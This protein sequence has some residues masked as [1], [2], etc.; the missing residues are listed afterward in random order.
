LRDTVNLKEEFGGIFTKGE[1]FVFVVKEGFVFEPESIAFQLTEHG[2][3]MEFTA[4]P[5]P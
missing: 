1:V 3:E 5:V 4:L 2:Y